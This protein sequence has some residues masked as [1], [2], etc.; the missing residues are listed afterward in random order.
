MLH[1]E[2]SRTSGPGQIPLETRKLVSR[3]YGWVQ[4][5]KYFLLKPLSLERVKFYLHAFYCQFSEC[6]PDNT[7]CT[8][9]QELHG[10]TALTGQP[11]QWGHIIDGCESIGHHHRIDTLVNCNNQSLLL[12]Y[13]KNWVTFHFPNVNQIYLFPYQNNLS[14]TGIHL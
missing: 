4:S 13:S 10:G 6:I 11:N 14:T 2:S 12:L 7:K 5:L 9:C 8:I 3:A 1:A